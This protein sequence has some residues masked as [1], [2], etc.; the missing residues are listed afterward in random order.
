MRW[1][2]SAIA[3]L[4]FSACTPETEQSISPEKPQY[5]G[6]A[7]CA[8]CHQPQH[9]AWQASHHQLAMTEP[10]D[11]SVVADFDGTAFER[12]TFQK[13]EDRWVVHTDAA[14]GQL[15][16]FDVRYTFG[17]EP[18]QQYLLEL[19]GNRL[20][21]LNIAWDTVGENWFHLYPDESID[22]DDVLHWT[23]SSHNWNY[24]CA[25]CHSTDVTKGYDA[26][27][28]TYATEFAEISV[29]C[30][31][32]HGPGSLH[33]ALTEVGLTEIGSIGSGM[34]PLA[35]Q[36]E[37]INSC[38]RCHSRRSQ[39]K[40]GFTAD[41]AYLDYYLPSL[42]DESLYH[43]DGQILDEVY[44]YGSFLQSKMHAQG[45]TC[46]NCH[47]AHSAKLLIE[48]NGLCTQCHN[49]T[50]RPDFPTLKPADYDS[51]AHLLHA[52]GEAGCVSCHMPERTYMGVDPRRD[53]SFRIPRPD[54]ADAIGVP[55]ACNACH[56]D[57]TPQWA[58]DVIAERFGAV[59]PHSYGP[60]FAAARN[61]EPSVEAALAAEGVDAE[62]P[63][64][65]RA[66]AMSLMA[67]YELGVTGFALE[68]GLRDP[69]PLVR[70]GAL[71]GAARWDAERRWRVS[72]HLL[73][74]PYLAVRIE[75]ARALM[76]A[77]TTLSVSDQAE[78]QAGIDE[79]LETQR[80]NADRAGSPDQHRFGLSR[81][82]R[83]CGC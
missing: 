47:D 79:Y 51:E 72:S 75:A 5:V 19:P 28:R 64:I 74:D 65:V 42:L 67:T 14:D 25:D 70:I 21:A 68:A 37:Q 20:Q 73:R 50:G 76:D 83:P 11:A 36:A 49:A 55:N 10:T 34:V 71:R 58:A 81:D 8:N 31:A 4:L 17:I 56:D 57:E 82:G 6:S 26:V 22:H 46:S 24:M 16:D 38:A 78:L 3:L 45:V 53:H 44:V 32:C 15:S 9:E 52:D 13:V 60:V 2:T 54:L 62:Q 61:G 41:D 33:V 30:E 77:F 35:T 63:A 43:P 27:E 69:S 23:K 40:E 12:T 48:G 39:L 18:L 1:I 59:R 7:A 29:G 80:L 66:T